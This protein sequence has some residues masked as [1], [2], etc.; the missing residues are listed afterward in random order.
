MSI[1]PV[2]I[3][4]CIKEKGKKYHKFFFRTQRHMHFLYNCKR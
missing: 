3:K 1:E 2:H 4:T